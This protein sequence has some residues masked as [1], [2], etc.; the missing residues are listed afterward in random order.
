[1]Y[2]ASYAHVVNIEQRTSFVFRVL[3][4]YNAVLDLRRKFAEH[5]SGTPQHIHMILG[6][7]E[8]NGEKSKIRFV[9]DDGTGDMEYDKPSS[10]ILS[11]HTYKHLWLAWHVSIDFI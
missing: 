3:A 11:C 1:M 10:G 6:T 8:S 4:C 5:T 7:S 2:N 9:W